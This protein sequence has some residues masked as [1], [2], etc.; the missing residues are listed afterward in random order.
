L[1]RTNIDL[2]AA[3]NGAQK[4]LPAAALVGVALIGASAS[5]GVSLLVP[6]A[7]LASGA[8]RTINRPAPIRALA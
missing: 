7:I 5:L 2:K 6:A 1:V 8:V 3:Q 4:V